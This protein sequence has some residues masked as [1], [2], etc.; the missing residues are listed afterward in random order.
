MSGNVWEW[1]SDNYDPGR[2]AYPSDEDPP[3]GLYRGMKDFGDMHY[4]NPLA[5]DIREARVGPQHGC[6]ERVVRGGSY[7]DPI[8]RC[9]VDVRMGVRPEVEAS[10]VGFRTVLNLP[11]VD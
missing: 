1:C 10:N 3:T 8:E 2:Y 7:R 11:P 9:R 5:K 4:P 6:G